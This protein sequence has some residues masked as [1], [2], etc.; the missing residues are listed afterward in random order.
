M[1]IENGKCSTG[2]AAAPARFVAV[3][4]NTPEFPDAVLAGVHGRAMFRVDS[5]TAAGD[6]N[7]PIVCKRRT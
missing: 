1:K 5:R 4:G 6:T 2:G 7:L 3:S